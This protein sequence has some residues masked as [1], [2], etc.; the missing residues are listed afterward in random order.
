[1]FHWFESLA[2][3][4]ALDT[5]SNVHRYAL[6]V[7]RS[8]ALL[9][10][11]K[12]EETGW[13]IAAWVRGGRE[14]FHPLFGLPG[15]GSVWEIWFLEFSQKGSWSTKIWTEP[16]CTK[17]L[18]SLDS[19]CVTV[20]SLS[21]SSQTLDYT[22]Y[23]HYWSSLLHQDHVTNS[24]F[25]SKFLTRPSATARLR[26]QEESPGI[27]RFCLLQKAPHGLSPP[28]TDFWSQLTSQGHL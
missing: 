12:R 4:T 24:I 13:N 25:G 3:L 15:Y 1:M 26:L 23:I 16:C 27:G 8:V 18:V 19:I 9:L 2:Q 6:E 7:F 5:C 21:L 28:V 10:G 22:W 17:T 11:S 14:S 20:V